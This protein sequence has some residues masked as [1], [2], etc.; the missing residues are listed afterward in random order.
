MILYA[1][2]FEKKASLKK[3]GFSELKMPFG[4][5]C[6]SWFSLGH[7]DAIHTCTLS[8][9][10]A[11]PFKLIQKSNSLLAEMDCGEHYFHP[12][13]LIAK[14]R[15]NMF[16]K[17][18]TSF[19]V[20]SRIHFGKTTGAR[21]IYDK[22]LQMLKELDPTCETFQLFHTI[23]LCDAVLVGKSENLPHLL[24]VSLS[25]RKNPGIARIYTYCAINNL[26][27]R[28]NEVVSEEER[29]P[30]CTIRFAVSS[31]SKA[32]GEINAIKQQCGLGE[33][34]PHFVTGVDDIVVSWP[35]LP[36]NTLLF[37]FRRWFTGSA[38][39]RL[40]EAFSSITTRLGIASVD[41]GDWPE[42]HQDESLS[43]HYLELE[44][45]CRDVVQIQQQE[46]SP[47]AWLRPISELSYSLLRLSQMPMLDEF[48]YLMLPGV[49]AF[50]LRLVKGPLPDHTA[51][52]L[53]IESWTNV[54]EQV[55]RTEGQLSQYPQLRPPVFDIPIA[56]LEYVLAFLN[57]V[58]LLL[59]KEDTRKH[60]IALFPV[61]GFYQRILASEL[62]SPMG[63]L[64]GLILIK[65]PIEMLYDSP[66]MQK[67]LCHE[68]SHYI[69]ESFRKRDIRTKKYAMAAAALLADQIFSYNHN[70]VILA[71]SSELLKRLE[72]KRTIEEMNAEVMG[73][74][75]DFR[76]SVQSLSSTIEVIKKY[77]EKK[78]KPD[79]PP[80]KYLPEILAKGKQT[81][82]HKFTNALR[83]ISILFREC[84]ADL[85]ML[86]LL[87]LSPSDYILGQLK[88]FALPSKS[89]ERPY[90][91]VGVRIYAVLYADNEL[92]PS[93]LS[94]IF[95]SL[96]CL[97][98]NQ[99]QVDNLV[100]LRMKDELL[101]LS[102]GIA[103]GVESKKGRRL[104]LLAVY[105]LCSY[106]KEC[107]KILKESISPADTIELRDMFQNVNSPN[108]NYDE[109]QK[110]IEEYRSK[111]QK[112]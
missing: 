60:Q 41:T 93:S 99:K 21:E 17:R 70:S 12:L 39:N 37:L 79:D 28:T 20:V 71:L 33:D 105:S 24:G 97:P 16:W 85:C 13:Y 35:N 63:N 65:I 101:T 36:V 98:T 69:G 104:P 72:G 15:A 50:L 66:E 76:E 18:R 47:P 111:L 45:L 96:L 102:R 100:F 27:L 57:H 19:L 46:P 110:R 80:L 32:N 3:E 31:F 112:T 77:D 89:D 94:E 49:R 74:L 86:H 53:F 84:F 67:T 87:S 26:F 106:L 55:M 1:V 81:N 8:Q 61:P 88:D 54:M 42:F 34:Q 29:L 56:M 59:Q 78:R 90:E 95:D 9:E 109:F 30:L 75:Y 10:Q 62:F 14:Y 23:E 43:R 82:E 107:K 6:Q 103:S 73:W 48:F 52:Q 22:L 38:E 92:S 64:P 58:A 7:F 83:D 5:D 68:M 25:L 11:N 51:F 2:I 108:M 44:S 91:Q 40:D 4:N